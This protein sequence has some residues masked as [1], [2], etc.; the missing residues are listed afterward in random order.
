MYL[1]VTY[2]YYS[3]KFWIWIWNKHETM[4]FNS[5]GTTWFIGKMIFSKY[6]LVKVIS[7]FY[8]TRCRFSKVVDFQGKT[9]WTGAQLD[10]A[11]LSMQCSWSLKP[12]KYLSTDSH[13][14]CSWNIEVQSEIS[15]RECDKFFFEVCLNAVCLL[16]PS[17]IHFVW[18]S[19][20]LEKTAP[21]SVNLGQ[22]FQQNC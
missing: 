3:I 2:D 6:I 18:K 21:G 16:R 17:P 8:T 7:Q 19:T 12:S 13:K 22:Y 5:H 9:N 14:V 20:P 15:A 11:S 1:I 4:H 10:F